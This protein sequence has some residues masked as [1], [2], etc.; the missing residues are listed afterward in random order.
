MRLEFLIRLTTQTGVALLG[1]ISGC[2]AKNICALCVR[3]VRVCA[4][5]CVLCACGVHVWCVHI[6]CGVGWCVYGWVGVYACVCVGGWVC[7]HVCVCVLCPYVCVC[8]PACVH[9]LYTYYD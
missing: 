2:P 5:A 8:V 6:V 7:M 9:S 3:A 1:A 4:C